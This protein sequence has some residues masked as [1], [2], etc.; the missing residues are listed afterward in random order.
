MEDTMGEAESPL[1]CATI[2]ATA[3]GPS[4]MT[5]YSTGIPYYATCKY[6]RTPPKGGVADQGLV[7]IGGAKRND[8]TPATIF[9]PR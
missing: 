7:R 4:V 8:C 9:L 1:L 3:G 6:P 2:A 5:A